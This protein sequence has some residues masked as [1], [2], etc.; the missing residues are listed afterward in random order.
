MRPVEADPMQPAVT[1][2]STPAPV[3]PA[4]IG[5][6]RILEPIAEGG[7]GRVFRSLD[8]AGCRMV[9]MKMP[10]S[11][12]APE[13]E[14]LR[15][16]AA[17]LTRVRHPGVVR[18]HASGSWDGVPW[19]AMELLE[20]CTLRD[21]IESM[22]EDA[23][24]RPGAGASGRDDT[25]TVP[26]RARAL[27]RAADI[28]GAGKPQAAAGRL[29]EVASIVVQL[30]MTLDH[31]HARGLVHRDVKPANVFLRDDGRVTLLD[32]GLACR[33]NAAAADGGE[34]L[35]VGT[36][37]YAAPE[38]ILGETV[39][40][41]SDVYSLGCV[42]YELTTGLR[43]FEGRS[44]HEIAQKHLHER[45]AP[46]SDVVRDLSWQLDALILEML[47]K[48]PAARP[49]TAGAAG[50]RLVTIVRRLPRNPHR[51]PNLPQ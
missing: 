20:G 21:E 46:P 25:P 6:Y 51:V 9:A 30:A 11:G 17:A 49:A 2:S 27:P 43:P 47:A 35:C 8:T 45:P 41:R 12:S 44:T 31:L 3:I 28:P 32:F 40:A 48:R 39:D 4:W 26:A 18:L 13:L 36:M 14:S 42:L 15:R 10:R 38:Q 16:E 7:M 50:Q 23:P 5:R 1:S 34:S 24:G 37:Q 22:W 19:L 29:P 33:A